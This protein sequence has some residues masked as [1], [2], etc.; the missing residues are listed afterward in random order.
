MKPFGGADGQ[1]H[2]TDGGHCGADG[3]N[4]GAPKTKKPVLSQS[5]RLPLHGDTPPQPLPPMSARQTEEAVRERRRKDRPT[6][7]RAVRKPAV[8]SIVPRVPSM[9]SILKP[10]DACRSFANGNWIWIGRGSVWYFKRCVKARIGESLIAFDPQSSSQSAPVDR[11]M[12]CAMR[13]I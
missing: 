12:L 4:G 5:S 11:S 1:S 13:Q 10:R 9:S 2:E 3:S 7:I 8:L 6:R